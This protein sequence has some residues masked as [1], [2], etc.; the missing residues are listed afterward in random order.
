MEAWSVARAVHV[1]AVVL[2]IGGVAMITTVL[3]PAVR[4]LKDDA[5]YTVFERL[6]RRF[7]TQSRWTTSIAGL[8][9]LY[10]IVSLNLWPRF[11]ELRYWWMH[12]MVLVW[13]VFTVL[14]F[15]LEPA[16][17]HRWYVERA[18]RDLPGT[19]KIIFAAHSV[20]LVIALVTV[21]G[22]VAGSHGL[23]VFQR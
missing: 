11:F 22:A 9:G 17:L 3:L 23:L 2:W 18:K 16:Y 4:D 7:A 8:T 5:A 19:L 6:E 1:V 13:A 14:L 10:L 15:V 20:L 21:A 12:T